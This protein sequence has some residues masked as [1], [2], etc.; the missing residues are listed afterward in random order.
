M[1]VIDLEQASN[2]MARD[3][4]RVCAREKWLIYS[5]IDALND[6]YDKGGT[7]IRPPPIIEFSLEPLPIWL[8]YA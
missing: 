3:I 6:M 4:V 7:T 5:Y 2:W 1:V 8:N